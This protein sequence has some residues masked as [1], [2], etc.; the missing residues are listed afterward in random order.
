[1][2]ET[3]LLILAVAKKKDKVR[4]IKKIL[5]RPDNFEFDNKESA[6]K[7]HSL[8]TEKVWLTSFHQVNGFK[9]DCTFNSRW[10][11]YRPGMK[12]HGTGTQCIHILALKVYL[13]LK[14]T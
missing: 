4:D 12:K 13:L 10:K 5:S 9:C 6:F 3:D 11:E 7:I 2:S 14:K 1:M 8:T